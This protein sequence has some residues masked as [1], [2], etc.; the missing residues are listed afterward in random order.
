MA[1]AILTTDLTTGAL[2]G[3][4]VFD[5]LMRSVKPHIKAEYDS[6]RIKGAEYSQ[7]YLAAVNSAM[8]QSIEFL[9][10][11][12]ATKAQNEILEQQK[13]QLV[14]ETASA[15]AQTALLT[16]QKSLVSKDILQRTQETLTEIENLNL[17]DFG[18]YLELEPDEEE[19]AKLEQNLQVAL[20]TGSV[21]LDDIIDIRQVRNLKMANQLLKLKKKKRH[22]QKIADQQANIQAQAQANAQSAEKAAMAEVQKQQ[23][24]TQ[25][26]VNVEQA[27]SQF[28][29]Q[30]MQIEAQIKKE[31]MAED[32]N[33][34]FQ[35]AKIKVD[36]E[37]DREIELEDRKDERTRI[38]ATQQSKMI[39]QRQNDELPKD[40]ESSGFGDLSG[41]GTASYTHLT[42]PTNREV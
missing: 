36:T 16:E 24:L 10:K 34:Q 12:D 29:I 42:L 11:Q 9:L 31:L 2:D 20:Q 39:A 27:K 28:E 38:Q 21:D 13:L 7:V 14:A 8:S 4:G 37:K 1:V 17:H 35:L 32:F 3:T 40:F 6:G 19:K 5:Q 41:F 26:K 30:R 15:V 18:I 25:E 33:Y 23:A 22:Q